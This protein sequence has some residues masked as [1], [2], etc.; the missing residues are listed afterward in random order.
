MGV[1][2]TGE[3]V[4]SVLYAAEVESGGG[5]AERAAVFVWAGRWGLPG[6]GGDAVRGQGGGEGLFKKGDELVIEVGT[7]RR[8]VVR[9][10]WRRC[11]RTV[12]H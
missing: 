3:L 5:N 7:L 12:L 11:D 2:Q 6:A 1:E 9:R 4:A 8:H 10:R